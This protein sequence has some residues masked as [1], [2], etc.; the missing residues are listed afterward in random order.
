MQ[1]VRLKNRCC[2]QALRQPDR[3]RN[4]V[5]YNTLLHAYSLH[6]KWQRALELFN[7]MRGELGME[8]DGYS[9]S[10]LLSGIAHSYQP[11]EGAQHAPRPRQAGRVLF[12]TFRRLEQACTAAAVQDC[13]SHQPVDSAA[14]LAGSPSRTFAH[15]VWLLSVVAVCQEAVSERQS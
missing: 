3:P 13:T 2:T 8:P 1:Q 9:V 14:T 10:S 5:I 12:C 6:G 15:V 4:L 11:V 7:Q